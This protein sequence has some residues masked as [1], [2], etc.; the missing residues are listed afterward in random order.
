MQG[1]VVRIVLLFYLAPLWTVP[2]ARI[3]LNEKLTLAGAATM[4]LA[5]AG[6]GVM[7]WQPALGFPLPRSADEWLGVLAGMG[8][9]AN[10]VL[11]RRAKHASAEAVSL[12]GAIGV[13]A[14]ALPVA[15]MLQPTLLAS[16]KVSPMDGFLLVALGVILLIT[17]LSMQYGLSRTAANRAA[18]ILLFELVVAAVGAH[19]LSNE[20]TR[21]QEWIGG[22]MIVLAG[23]VAT[24]ETYPAESAKV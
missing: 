18:V 10:N 5:L 14:I 4:L 17:A 13:F 20:V 1:E 19:Y 7:L 22:A 23:I 9:A 3:L 6:A 2:L 15:F 21:Q 16:L 12:A 11:I 24:I 8:F